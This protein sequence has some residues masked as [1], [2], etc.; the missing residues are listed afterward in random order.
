M[1]QSPKYAHFPISNLAVYA[2][3]LEKLFLSTST[4][5]QYAKK[6]K[7]SRPRKRKYKSK[8][9]VGVRASKVNQIWHVD[10]SVM[11]L[12]DNTKVFIQAIIDNYS[13]CI[14]AWE[15]FSKI[16]GKNTKRLIQTAC[17]N[18]DTVPELYFD[19]GVENLN[20]HVLSLSSVNQVIAQIDV[21]Y[22]NSMIEAFFR[23]MKNNFLYFQ[24]LRSVETFKRKVA[25]YVNEH[26]HKIPHSA[27]RGATPGENFE[28][29]W[30]EEDSKKLKDVL[31]N[32]FKKRIEENRA[33]IP[34]P[35]CPSI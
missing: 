9:K 26:N 3:K 15:T 28:N 22:S 19:S 31:K 18:M 20:K 35:G 21:H 27:L 16:D 17:R 12:V 7:W 23:S 5:L 10:I 11:K 13:R 33:I 30:G 2:A 29:K 24:D 6:F 25:Y 34:C 32:R 14:V 8:N 4:W 1:I